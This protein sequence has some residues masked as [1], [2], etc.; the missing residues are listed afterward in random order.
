[1]SVIFLNAAH[2]PRSPGGVYG[3]LTEHGESMRLCRALK[4][5]LGRLD[6]SLDV[7]IYEGNADSENMHPDDVLLVLH[8]GHNEKNQYKRSLLGLD[9]F[10]IY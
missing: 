3:G 4:Y 1:M 10:G 8:K 9:V 2:T 6:G 5:E 7:R